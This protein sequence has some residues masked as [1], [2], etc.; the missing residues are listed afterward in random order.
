MEGSMAGEVGAHERLGL[1]LAMAGSSQV[2][3]LHW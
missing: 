2:T 3:M 1:R